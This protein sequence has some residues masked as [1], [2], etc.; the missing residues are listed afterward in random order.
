MLLQRSSARLVYHCGRPTRGA[1]QVS[2]GPNA[3]STKNKVDGDCEYNNQSAPVGHPTLRGTRCIAPPVPRPAAVELVV[4]A[5]VVGVATA[6]MRPQARFPRLSPALVSDTATGMAGVSV[7]IPPAGSVAARAKMSATTPAAR[8]AEVATSSA[9][10]SVSESPAVLAAMSVAAPAARLTSASPW[11]VQAIEP[12]P[13]SG[14]VVRDERLSVSRAT[15]AVTLEVAGRTARYQEVAVVSLPEFECA[16]APPKPA[17]AVMAMTAAAVLVA[18]MA[19][20]APLLPQP[21]YGAA[22]PPLW[23]PPMWQA[24]KLPNVQLRAARLPRAMKMIL[25][26]FP[27]LNKDCDSNDEGDG[28]V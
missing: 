26:P 3:D 9:K 8:S 6:P 5:V 14:V 17:V 1:P 12:P 20:P 22:Q 21:A 7:G 28:Q 23:F 11:T 19:T 10:V 25:W 18:V 15:P 4:S 2:F 24:A 13:E 27:P 16:I